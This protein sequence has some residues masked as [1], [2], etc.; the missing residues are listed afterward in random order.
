[1]FRKPD[2]GSLISKGVLNS[3]IG[4]EGREEGNRSRIRLVSAVHRLMLLS[5]G[6]RARAASFPHCPSLQANLPPLVT[7]GA[8][9][10]EFLTFAWLSAALSS[11]SG[12]NLT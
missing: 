12:A 9:R 8:V 3:V 7:V 5:R 6:G 1:M 10:E 2:N 4:K 11:K